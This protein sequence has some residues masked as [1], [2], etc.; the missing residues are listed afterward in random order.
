MGPLIDGKRGQ[1]HDD[2]RA[3]D[4]HFETAEAYGKAGPGGMRGLR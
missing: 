3:F 4:G 1:E 2:Y